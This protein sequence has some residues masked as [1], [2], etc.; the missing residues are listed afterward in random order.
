MAHSIRKKAL[1]CALL[2]TGD[3]IRHV[4]TATGVP[5]ST[6]HR[7]RKEVCIPIWRDVAKKHNMG[8]LSD[9]LK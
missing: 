2:L 4:A 3:S 9:I 5:R 7:W 1:A 8:N 6:V